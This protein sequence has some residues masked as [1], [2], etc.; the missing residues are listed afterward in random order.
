MLHAEIQQVFA[1]RVRDKRR[2]QQSRG[3]LGRETGADENIT[4]A[5]SIFNRLLI[6]LSVCLSIRHS[7]LV[8]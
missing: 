3:F 1:N 2:Q 7:V 8:V 4:A 5:F 6:S